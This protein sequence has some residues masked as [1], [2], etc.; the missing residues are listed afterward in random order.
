[1]RCLLLFLSK[2]KNVNHLYRTAIGVIVFIATKF[3]ATINATTPS[4]ATHCAT[5]LILGALLLVRVLIWPRCH[6]SALIDL[7]RWRLVTSI[8]H[9]LWRRSLVH[10]R[11]NWR[12]SLRWWWIH[13]W[14]SR[15]CLRICHI[16]HFFLRV[17]LMG[18][19]FR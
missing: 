2:K 15:N 3:H 1:M 4:Q 9:C 16:R 17:I 8:G 10:L 5:S 14:L 18:L 6:L 11:L 19:K 7:T 12:E 13:L